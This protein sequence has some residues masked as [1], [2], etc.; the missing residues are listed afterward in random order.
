MS[1][2]FDDICSAA[3]PPEAL[4]LLAPLRCEPGL[5]IATDAGRIWLRF[6]PGSER[7]LRGILPLCA[8]ELFAF[9]DGTWRRFG[10]S[11]PAFDFPRSA[12]FEPLYQVLF[13]AAVLPVPPSTAAIA[14]VR[15]RVTPDDR[16]RPTAAMLCPLPALSAWADRVPCTRLERLHGVVRAGRILVIGQGLP[17][18]DGATRYWGKL[19]LVPLGHRPEPDLPESALREAARV[20]AEELLMLG[21]DGAAAIPRTALRQL[22]RAG[23]RAVNIAATP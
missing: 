7:V 4:P 22:S 14:L 3:L 5:Q 15:V 20:E 19:V 11:L 17:L 2:P 23:L 13:P 12:R 1:T 21:V 16:S 18:L 8:V 6:E 9:R 10:Q